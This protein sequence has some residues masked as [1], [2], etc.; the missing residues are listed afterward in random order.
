[1]KPKPFEMQNPEK[2]GGTFGYWQFK[3]T[4]DANTLEFLSTLPMVTDLEKTVGNDTYIVRIDHRYDYDH[5]AAWLEIYAALDEFTQQPVHLD[6]T[7]W[8]TI[9][10][11]D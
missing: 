5:E 7:I 11:D 3:I 6:P 9:L 4:A 10:G 2:H 8:G 1:M